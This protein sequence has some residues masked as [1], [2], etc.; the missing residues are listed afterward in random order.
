MLGFNPV[1]Y[2]SQL[3][4]PQCGGHIRDCQQARRSTCLIPNLTFTCYDL[5]REA[6]HVP[7]FRAFANQDANRLAC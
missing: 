6:K 7:R 5:V 2:R 3:A 1:I 4:I